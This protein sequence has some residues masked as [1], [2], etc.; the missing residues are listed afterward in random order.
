MPD[1][2]DVEQK[3]QEQKIYYDRSSFKPSC[4]GG[5]EVLVFNRTV[6]KM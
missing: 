2:M 6:K 3:S 4:K 1:F 5:E